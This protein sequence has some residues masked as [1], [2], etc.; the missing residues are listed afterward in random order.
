MTAVTESPLPP[1][2]RELKTNKPAAIGREGET[3]CVL[4]WDLSDVFILLLRMGRQ[5]CF[6][7]PVMPFLSSG[8]AL[9]NS[10]GDLG[11]RIS[12]DFYS[13]NDSK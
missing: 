11:L 6:K 2:S 9:V 5:S 10:P 13:Q 1:H 7:F 12:L 3:M 8:A 4:L